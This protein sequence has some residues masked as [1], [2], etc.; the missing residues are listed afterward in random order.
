LKESWDLVLVSIEMQ[1]L[2]HWTVLQTAYS[3]FW[4]FSMQTLLY[5][6]SILYHYLY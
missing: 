2:V 1:I 4:L 5:K 3:W 6:N